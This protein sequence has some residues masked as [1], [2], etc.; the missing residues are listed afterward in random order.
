MGVERTSEKVVE[1]LQLART[2]AVEPRGK[3]VED[4][5]AGDD[6]EEPLLDDGDEDDGTDDAAGCTDCHTEAVRQGVV[7]RVDVLGEPILDPAE[8]SRVEEAHRRM[9][10]TVGG[11]VVQALRDIVADQGRGDT[12]RRRLDQRRGGGLTHQEREDRLENAE[13]GVDSFVCTAQC[14]ILEENFVAP[15]DSQKPI[16]WLKASSCHHTRA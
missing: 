16:G 6:E 13:H 9:E 11:G 1:T 3:G 7:D 12:W 8:R 5:D 14:K 2:L 15:N 10:D 4:E